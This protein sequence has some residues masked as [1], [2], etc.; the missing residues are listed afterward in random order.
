MDDDVLKNNAS[1]PAKELPNGKKVFQINPYET[2]F[3]YQ[4]IFVDQV[5]LRHGIELTKDSIVFDVGAN[6]GLFSL[7]CLEQASQCQIYAFEPSPELAE[8]YQSNLA[9][10]KNQV[11][12]F[13]MGLGRTETTANFVYY[14]H[15]SIMSGFFTDQEKDTRLLSKGVAQQWLEENPDF[16][17]AP[18]PLIKMI[19]AQKL[20]AKKELTLPVK[21]ISGILASSSLNHIDLLKIDA[22]LSELEILQGID[23]ADWPKIRQLVVEVNDTEGSRLQTCEALLKKQGFSVVIEQEDPFVESQV[24]NVFGK[25]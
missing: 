20:S 25:K 22:E 19:A 24:Y 9:A 15:Y 14:P 1:F 7:F 11:H 6:I 4:E 8:I 13:E 2:D 3:L 12:F 18:E 23:V 16:E 10:F 21:T 17:T 5:Y